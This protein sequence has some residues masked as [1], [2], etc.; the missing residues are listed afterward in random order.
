MNEEGVKGAISISKATLSNV[1][2]YKITLTAD[3]DNQSLST[4]FQI[5]IEGS[6][7]A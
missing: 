1:G 6:C 5:R 3:V 4:S 7:L 2:I